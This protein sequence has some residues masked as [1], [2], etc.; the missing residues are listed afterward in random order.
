MLRSVKLCTKSI[1]SALF[2]GVHVD[3]KPQQ[4]M[5]AT[6]ANA[7]GGTIEESRVFRGFIDCNRNE[8]KGK[9]TAKEMETLF[10]MF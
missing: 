6:S 4:L 9:S 1:Q 7:V 5:K 8:S 2:H 3:A 10:L